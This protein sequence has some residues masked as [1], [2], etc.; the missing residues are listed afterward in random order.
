MSDKWFRIIGVPFIGIAAYYFQWIMAAF[1]PEPFNWQTLLF[2]TLLILALY[3]GNRKIIQL[4]DIRRVP[5]PQFHRRLI[6]Q[7]LWTIVFS[8]VCINGCYALLKLYAVWV[9][10]APDGI[11]LYHLGY[12]NSIGLL[13]VVVVNSIQLLL[14]FTNSWQEE[15]FAREQLQKENLQSQLTA[16]QHQINPH[17]LFNSFN[18]LAELIDIDQ[19]EAR[20]FVENFSEIYHY[21]LKSREL[22]L[23]HLE[24]ELHFL[25]AYIF[26]L[27][28]RYTSGL[29]MRLNIEPSAKNL[30]LPPMVLQ[31]LLENAVKHNI[32][33]RGRPLKIEIFTQNQQLTIRNN[34]QVRKRVEQNSTQTGWQ[35]IQLRYKALSK[36]S[37]VI[38]NN[39]RTYEVT[40]PL[41]EV[42]FH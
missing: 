22:D 6:R 34:L 31:M 39:G 4:I 1:D 29:E 35:N 24:D 25:E 32:I 40:I 33:S 14:Y 37:P 27:Q 19:Q 7:F 12:A 2:F 11:T 42:D 38:S 10:G 18:V 30:W 26:L 28:K 8:V 36:Q 13:L 3:E 15:R 9:W 23:T 20:K 5:S 21:V 16:L 41:L 17:F